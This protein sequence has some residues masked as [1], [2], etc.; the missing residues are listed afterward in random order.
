MLFK[1]FGLTKLRMGHWNRV[2]PGPYFNPALVRQSIEDALPQKGV[3]WKL[4]SAGT[5]Y[6]LEYCK[7]VPILSKGVIGASFDWLFAYLESFF[8]YLLQFFFQS[9]E[10]ISCTA[11][12]MLYEVALYKV[13]GAMFA[14]CSSPRTSYLRR[15]FLTFSFFR[16][17]L[18]I[19]TPNAL[20]HLYHLSH[21]FEYSALICSKLNNWGCA[22]APE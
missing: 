18:G 12:L 16:V 9:C 2:L 10:D 7:P 4:G 21:S 1:H 3:C 13:A 5:N 14:R 8:I 11:F 6:K 19:I 22:N 20:A 17:P 15:V